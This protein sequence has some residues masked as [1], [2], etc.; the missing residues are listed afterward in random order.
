MWRHHAPPG[1]ATAFRELVA[2]LDAIVS[3][4]LHGVVLGAAAGRRVIGI[5]YDPKAPRFLSEIGVPGQALPL[6]AS[7]DDIVD[8]IR[9]SLSDPDL[10]RRIREGVAVARQRTAAL[11][12][13]IAAIAG[14]AR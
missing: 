5:G 11:I 6:D 9:R 13:R 3:V 7:A 8:A 1:S 12:P 2:P 10:E 14:R 4:R